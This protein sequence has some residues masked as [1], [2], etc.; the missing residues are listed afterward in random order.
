MKH[1]DDITRL[2]SILGSL[3]EPYNHHGQRV[4]DYAMKLAC[5][6]DLPQHNVDLIRV[7]AYLH[8]IGKLR[9]DPNLLN[10]PRK[11]SRTER[12]EMERHTV[13]GW[14]VAKEAGYDEEVCDAIRYH[15]ERW[16]GKG[17]PDQLAGK[18]IPLSAQIVGVCDAY[19]ALTSQR[20]YREAFSHN[21]AMA[22]IQKD[23]GTAFNSVLVDL[24]FEKVAIA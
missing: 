8:D 18:G 14:E 21:F 3:R 7:G 22:A 6:Y 17:Y 13:L 11:Y 19:D 1:Y 4:A 10:L 24:F 5:E 23:K 16:D 9:I 12:A 2:V 15:H 20:V